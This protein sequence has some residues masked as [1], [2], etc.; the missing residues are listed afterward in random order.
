[1]KTVDLH[2]HSK[3]SLATSK[4]MT[5]KN[6]AYFSKIKGITHI[7][8]GDLFHSGWLAEIEKNLTPEEN[9]FFKLKNSKNSPHFILS[10]EV[11]LVFGEKGNK[12]KVHILVL[13]SDLKEVKTLKKAFSHYGNLDSNGRPF[14]K[15]SLKELSKIVSDETNHTYL[16]PAHIWTPHYSIF[17]ANSGFNSLE[18]AFEGEVS[19]RI[20]AMETGLS[21]DPPMNWM[22]KDVMR[23]NLVSNSDSHSPFKIGRELNVFDDFETFSQLIMA[24]K[25][26]GG[27]L[28]TVEYF[29][30]EGK[31]HYDG[32]RKCGVSFHPE[33]T[34]KN[35]SVCPVCKRKLTIG[36]LN[37]VYQL[38]DI[39]GKY[40]GK[41]IPFKHSIPL[42][43]IIAKA[44]NKPET[45]K[46]VKNF[47]FKIIENFGNEFKILFEVEPKELSKNG[48]SRM[49]LFI[50]MLRDEKLKVIPGYDGVYGKIEFLTEEEKD[51]I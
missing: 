14:L 28:Y 48:F 18:E 2:I 5:L 8:T 3:Y 29:P 7:A 9:G 51:G 17:G 27:F 20:I 24:I 37:R 32:H 50:K 49:A 10:G 34:R 13:S 31:Y 12:K 19:E 33:E 25:T 46:M 6:I 47:Y 38:S 4:D 30:E 1:M 39:H 23:Y 21:S 26:G 43:E 16:I 44:M 42:I 11:S 40:E 35:N 45:T 36:V 41:K 15:L 22:V